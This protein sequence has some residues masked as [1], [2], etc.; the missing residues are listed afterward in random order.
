MGGDTCWFPH[1]W[2]VPDAKTRRVGRAPARC[3]TKWEAI[4]LKKVPSTA[5]LQRCQLM[6]SQN[7]QI[8]LDPRAYVTSTIAPASTDVT[9]TND[10][11]T[12]F[13]PQIMEPCVDH[14]GLTLTKVND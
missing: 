13:Q 3:S 1:R 2:W 12:V 7:Q 6:S 14:V 11:I 8:A 9:L 10:M 5:E 4:S